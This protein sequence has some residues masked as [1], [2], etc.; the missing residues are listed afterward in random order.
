MFKKITA[1]VITLFCISALISPV[2]MASSQVSAG[3]A[4]LNIVTLSANSTVG[5]VITSGNAVVEDE[6]ASSLVTKAGSGTVAAI[7]GLFFNSYY[8]GSQ[9]I[10]FPDNCPLILTTVVQDGQVISGGCACNAVLLYPDGTTSIDKLSIDPKAYINGG[11]DSIGIWTVNGANTNSEAVIHITSEMNLPY[12]VDSG[13]TAFLITNG[14]VTASYSGGTTLTLSGNQELLIYNS[15]SY[16]SHKGWS[17][18]P[19]VGDTVTFTP[20]IK[21]SR[22]ATVTG[23]VDIVGGGRML[24]HNGTN[25]NENSSYNSVLDYD[26]KQDAYSTLQRSFIAT[27]PDGSILLGTGTASFSQIASQLLSMGATNA[28]SLDG[29]ASSMLYENGSYVTY[30]GRELASIIAFSSLSSGTSTTTTEPTITAIPTSSAVYV[31]GE[32]VDFPTYNIDGNN[33]VKLRDLASVMNGTAKQFGVEYNSEINLV[34]LVSGSAYTSVGG[35][36]ATLP[37]G[38]I[39]S[40][41]AGASE[42]LVDGNAHS[43][44]AYLI[45]GNNFIK[46][47]DIGEIFDFGVEW[48]EG[49]RAIIIDSS[50]GYTG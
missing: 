2:A 26:S 18:V 22:G 46:L 42:I 48:D 47:R 3:G 23:D 9:A 43:P 16:V 35:E 50:V 20:S 28:M 49:L 8:S 21:T 45:G 29:G 40:V 27:M 4:T 14:K 5:Q 30:A 6:A 1:L 12:T 33:Y 41:T 19:S 39:S 37:T 38:D 17:L 13:S 10:S 31:D 11:S 32:Y 44:T 36:M 15:A 34:S 24:I 25:V 7:N